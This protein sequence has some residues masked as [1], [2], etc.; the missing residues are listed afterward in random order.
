MEAEH[1]VRVD[2]TEAER[3]LDVENHSRAVLEIDDRELLAD[4][5]E[6]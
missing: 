2:F 3:R 5:A 4:R 1:A 6:K